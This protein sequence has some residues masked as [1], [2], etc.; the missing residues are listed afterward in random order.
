MDSNG[1]QWI[2]VDSYGF[3]WIH[4]D[5]YGSLWIPMDL[6]GFLWVPMDSCGFQWIPVY[7]YGFL[8]ISTEFYRLLWIP[9]EFY[10]ITALVCNKVMVTSAMGWGDP[11]IFY[12]FVRLL[13]HIFDC[14]MVVGGFEPL[15]TS[16][17]V[18]YVLTFTVPQACQIH[19]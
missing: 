12:G 17:G 15:V 11:M 9:T 18:R 8:G 5:S 2:P 4:M 6:Y 14:S 10:G 16:F 19:M 7:S 1:F 3:L 13:Y